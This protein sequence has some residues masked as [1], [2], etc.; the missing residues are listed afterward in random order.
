MRRKKQIILTIALTAV[1]MSLAVIAGSQKTA[2]DYVRVVA[3][4]ADIAAGSQIQAEQLAFVMIPSSLKIQGYVES[5]EAVEGLWTSVVLTA[6]ELINKN[7]LTESAAG[8][9][10]PNP[11]PGRRLLTIKLDS[12]DAVGYWLTAG[13]LV[14]LFL[15]PRGRE[16]ESAIQ[17][18]EKVRIMAIIDEGTGAAVSGFAAAAPTAGRL[19]C[20]DLNDQQ[21]YLIISLQGTHDIRLAAINELPPD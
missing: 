13:S 12:A 2:E 6:G 11:G 16:L 7:R 17:I 8:I 10:Y 4:K 19:L 9:A 5:P 21:V 3:V 14:D 1:L 18:M 20:L 15:V